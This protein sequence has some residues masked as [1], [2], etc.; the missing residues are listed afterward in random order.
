MGPIRSLEGQLIGFT[1]FE[2][3]MAPIYELIQDTTGLGETGETLIAKKDGDQALFLNPLLHDPDAALKRNIG[4]GERQAIPVQ[5]ALKGG[6]GSGISIDYRGQEVI[7]AWRYL[8]LL[9]WAM[10]AKIDLAEAFKPVAALR[11]FVLILAIA[12]MVLSIGVAFIVA[13]SISEPILNL[14]AGVE[15]VGKGNL[16][17][18]VATDA[19]DEIGQLGRAFDQMTV[20]LKA[21]TASRD[22]LDKEIKERKKTEKELQKIMSEVDERIK[23]LNCFFGISR[24]V[25]RRGLNLEE[26]LQGIVDLIPPAWQYPENTCANINLKDQE[27]RTGNFKETQWGLTQS[28][29]VNDKAVGTLVVYYLEE[30]PESDEGPFLKEERNLINS[31]AERIG[32]II[33]RNRAQ[34]AL[35]ESEERF[36]ELVE[37]SLTGISIIQDNQIVYQNPE[38]ERL[39]GALP[40]PIKFADTDSIHPDDFNKV[41]AFYQKIS[42]GNLPFGAMDFR[43]YPPGEKVSRSNLKWVQCQASRIEYLGKDAI[44]VN[45][46][47]MTKA[48]ELEH[49][50]TIQDKMASLGRVAAGIAHEIRN[51]LSGINIYLNTLKKLHHKAGSEEKVEQILQHVNSAS[52]KIESVIRR[53]MDFAKP[54]EPKLTLIDI[55]Q[56]ITDAVNLTAVTMR[57]SGVNLQK[58]L[59]DDLPPTYADS[60]LIEE[61]VLNLLNNAAEAMKSMEEGKK[62][63]VTTSED[64]DRIIVRV[65]DSGPGVPS[66]IRDKIFDPYFTTRPEGTGI[67]LSLSHRIITDHG[68]SLTVADSDLGGAEFRIEIPIKQ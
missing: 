41:N 58:Q 32:R 53:V 1:V 17:H 25:E 13:K 66:E 9:D 60:N 22:E 61:M 52:H 64:S 38:Q 68:G 65:S 21:V 42:T 16:D 49:L 31:I 67:G 7:A 45:M 39:L 34:N 46:M 6:S 27:F 2:I 35:V 57:K 10:V 62:I 48:K 12:V 33:E 15:E 47:D 8:P 37:H 50:L 20:Q 23:E 54:S 55:N 14:Q 40:R 5:K 3:D 24:L 30:R 44:L 18:R 19:K 11:D 26:I 4:L 36:R 56:P 43:F 29:V 28:I 63:I 51:P 59:A